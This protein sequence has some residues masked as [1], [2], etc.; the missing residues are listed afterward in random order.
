MTHDQILVDNPEYLKRL[1]VEGGLRKV[2][3][4]IDITQAGRPGFPIRTLR[5]DS[6]LHPLRAAFVDLI[7]RVRRAT[8]TDVYDECRAPRVVLCR[9]NCGHTQRVD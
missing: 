7:L 8:R 1:V 4:H 9:P 5:R 2:G 3:I 6:D